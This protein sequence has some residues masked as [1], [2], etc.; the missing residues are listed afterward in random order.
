MSSACVS[1]CVLVSVLSVCVYSHYM[2]SFSNLALEQTRVAI[3]KAEFCVLP[4]TGKFIFLD[5][6]FFSQGYFNSKHTCSLTNLMCFHGKKKEVDMTVKGTVW[7]IVQ[8]K[9]LFDFLI[10]PNDSS[11]KEENMFLSNKREEIIPI[12]GL[13]KSV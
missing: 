13:N 10:L 8:T 7:Y 5:L 6:L 2:C 9:V 11:I 12:K 3:K 4:C 1:A